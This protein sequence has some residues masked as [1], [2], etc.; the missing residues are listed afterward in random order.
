[1]T[2]DRLAVLLT[3]SI[4]PVNS[5]PLPLPTSARTP[6]CQRVS[7][8]AWY[9]NPAP[10]STINRVSEGRHE[11]TD[12]RE[13]QNIIYTTS[14][15]DAVVKR[16]CGNSNSAQRH[17]AERTR[18]EAGTRKVERVDDEEG[19]GAGEAAGREVDAEEGPELRLGAV[20][21]EEAL[22]RV[23]ERKVERLQTRRN[24]SVEPKSAR[25]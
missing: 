15:R 1:M 4:K 22:D 8:C 21:G 19:T 10:I 24:V 14:N 11:K 9:Q 18:G 12:W 7:L 23:L 16:A 3:Q 6:P 17:A 20:L 25:S 13:A 2:P 5:R